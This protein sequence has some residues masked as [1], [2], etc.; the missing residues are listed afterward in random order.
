MAIASVEVDFTAKTMKIQGSSDSISNV[1]TYVDT[2]KFTDFTAK[3]DTQTLDPKKAFPSVV[4]SN[5]GKDDKGASYEL[6][7]TY[8]PLIFDGTY[9]VDLKVP[10]GKITTRSET[11]KPEPLFQ[12]L[13]NNK[14]EQ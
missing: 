5:F 10:A 6:N 13:S 8:D 9:N 11:E 1:N 3:Q 7:I 2:L 12:P 14:V 4:L